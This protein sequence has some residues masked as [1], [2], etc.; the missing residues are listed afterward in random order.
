MHFTLHRRLQTLAPQELSRLTRNPRV[1][2]APNPRL[3]TLKARGWWGAGREDV[4]GERGTARELDHQCA[5]GQGHARV[6]VPLALCC[7]SCQGV[8]GCVR[9]CVRACVEIGLGEDTTRPRV[10]W[11]VDVY[12]DVLWL[13]GGGPL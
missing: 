1:C 4:V 8:L 11:D 12:V 13:Y 2:N 6:S 5:R 3:Q 10:N 9:A 7:P